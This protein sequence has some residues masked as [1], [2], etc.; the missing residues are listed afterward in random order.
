MSIYYMS[1]IMCQDLVAKDRGWN[2]TDNIPYR[3]YMLVS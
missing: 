3:I 1:G 2:E